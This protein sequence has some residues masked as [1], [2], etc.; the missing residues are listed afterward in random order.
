MKL[1]AAPALDLLERFGVRQAAAL[2]RTIGGH[3][4]EAVGD[5]Q[6][7]RGERQVVDLRAVVPGAVE[8]LPVVLDRLRLRRGEAETL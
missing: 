6:E 8:P 7:V 5:D 2:E 3:R 1:R 4:V